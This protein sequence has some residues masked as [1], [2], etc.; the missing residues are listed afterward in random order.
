[1]AGLGLGDPTSDVQEGEGLGGRGGSLSG[2]RGEG[3]LKS[4][5]WRGAMHDS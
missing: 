4:C 1:M 3:S 2:V 5:G